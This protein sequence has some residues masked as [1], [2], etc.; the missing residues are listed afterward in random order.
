[1]KKAILAAVLAAV[2]LPAAPAL[3]DPPSWAPAHG[4]RAHEQ[5]QYQQRYQNG[6]SGYRAYQPRNGYDRRLTNNDRIWRGN[7]GR[8]YC[9]RTDGSTGL[10]IGAGVG[11]LAGSAIASNRDQTLGIILGA[12]GGGI[13]G[14]SIDRGNIRCR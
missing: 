11:A 2:V 1:M 3:A 7:D 10:V 12:L 9:H 8:T 6:Y 13:A 5:S 4:R 14:R